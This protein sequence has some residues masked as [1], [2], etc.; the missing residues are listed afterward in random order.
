VHV[1]V[2]AS[3]WEKSHQ[4][5]VQI[6]LRVGKFQQRRN[7]MAAS[8]RGKSLLQG[9]WMY[10]CRRE[11]LLLPVSE[12]SPSAGRLDDCM[13]WNNLVATSKGV[14]SIFGVSG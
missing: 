3:E 9:I 4:L 6:F 7:F 14:V 12:L 2:I 1:Y 11:I 5:N 8:E 13:L 10:I